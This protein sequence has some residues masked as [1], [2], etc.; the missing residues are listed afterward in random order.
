VSSVLITGGRAPV[1]LDVARRLGRAGH[2]VVVAESLWPNLTASS[3]YIAAAYSVP[4]P[5]RDFAGFAVVMQSIVVREGIDLIIPTC[6]EVFYLAKLAPQLPVLAPDFAALAQL[7]NKWRFVGLLQELRLR[8]PRTW[9]LSNVS[10]LKSFFPA[11]QDIV[12]KPVYSRFAAKTQVIPRGQ[13]PHTTPHLSEDTPWLAQ[14][15]IGGQELCS[16][17]LAQAGRIVL[18]V[19]YRPVM[20]AGIGAGIVFEAIHHPET[21]SIATT[22]AQHLRITGQIAFDYIETG[23]GLCV[24]ECNP[25]STSGIHLFDDDAAVVAALL[26]KDAALQMV[27]PP[28]TRKL[29]LP[30]LLYAPNIWRDVGW[31]QWWRVML[32]A[33]DVVFDRQDP[34]PT[35][36]QLWCALAL[37]WGSRTSKTTATPLEYSTA[38]IEWNGHDIAIV[39]S[40]GH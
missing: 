34:R 8:A 29:L 10:Q 32:A 4:S 36:H 3:R 26:G 23:D 7:H 14:T 2:R 1:A 15:R 39:A 11:P 24:L 12:L 33:Q 38:D 17:S 35:L 19:A 22:I 6:E 21:L 30:M 18:H 16:Y 9:L 25:R 27:Q 40:T 20:R 37:W 13:L 31:G 28:Q 5:R